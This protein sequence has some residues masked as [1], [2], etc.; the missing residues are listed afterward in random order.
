MIN[1]SLI[2]TVMSDDKPGVVELLSQTIAKHDGN[3]LKSR[4]SYMAGKF[5]GILVINLPQ[6]NKNKLLT[7]LDNLS[8]YG[9]SVTAENAGQQQSEESYQEYIIQ[10]TSN[11][12]PG[13]IKEVSQVLAERN[14]NLL[15]LNSDSSSA[16]MTGAPL[17]QATALVQVPNDVDVDDLVT[18]L[19]NIAND[20][21]IEFHIK[22]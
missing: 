18:R 22:S 9:L 1:C 11:D 8:R 17:F 4:M 19:E 3:W 5:A 12:R 21:M 7:D 13:I 10:L 15:D 20:L 16:P 14:V 2:L 6:D